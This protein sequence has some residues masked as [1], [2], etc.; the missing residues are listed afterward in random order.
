MTTTWQVKIWAENNVNLGHDKKSRWHF[1][2]CIFQEASTI[3]NGGR[4][5]KEEASTYRRLQLGDLMKD[6]RAVDGIITVIS[7][8][9]KRFLDVPESVFSLPGRFRLRKM[10]SCSWWTYG[11]RLSLHCTCSITGSSSPGIALFGS[12]TSYICIAILCFSSPTLVT[13]VITFR[14]NN[15]HLINCNT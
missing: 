4:I 5:K 9:M 10:H 1:S 11:C 2:A 6:D 15:I 14:C 12:K 13:V 7:Q 3:E 8:L